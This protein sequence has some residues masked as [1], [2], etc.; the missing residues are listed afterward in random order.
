VE[1][2]KGQNSILFVATLGVFGMIGLF[3]VQAFG[4]QCKN[5]DCSEL[6]DKVRELEVKYLWFNE[7]SIDEYA[8]LVEKFLRSFP[9]NNV[10]SINVSWISTN[11]SRP[12]R[13]LEIGAEN[14]PKPSFF[15]VS[16]KARQEVEEFIL[17][18]GNGLPGTKFSFRFTRDSVD[19]GFELEIALPELKH[20]LV[21]YAYSLALDLKRCEAGTE[22]DREILRSSKV[23]VNRGK[24]IFSSRVSTDSIEGYL[25]N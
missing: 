5:H 8:G 13:S 14:S 7:K 23:E 17:F 21:E 22:L 24:L 15:P 19:T 18:T 10:S 3:S 1:K 12:F 11:D 4:Q 2:R 20:D 16:L 6:G 25:V 9:K